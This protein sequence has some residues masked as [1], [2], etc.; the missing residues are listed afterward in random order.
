MKIH[1]LLASALSVVAASAGQAAEPLTPPAR[2]KALMLYFSKSFGG[3][4]RQARNPL[5]FGL[6]L[7]ESTLSDAARS[8][9]LL[10]L[11]YSLD[12]RAMLIA[13]DV[14]RW[15][16]SDSSDDP[17]SSMP[18]S[19]G[20]HWGIYVA[21]GIGVLAV[22]CATHVGICEDHKNGTDTAGGTDTPTGPPG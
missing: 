14:L 13:A 1:L 22:A 15:D 17:E 5:A 20:Q 7:Q 2:E 3:S 19:A 9:P 6:R 16:P 4:D 8:V 21:A 11:R 18:S 12:G 10:D